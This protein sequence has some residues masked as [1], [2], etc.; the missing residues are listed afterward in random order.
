MGAAYVRAQQGGDIS[1]PTKVAAC[2]KHYLGYS[3]PLSG[4]DRTPAWIPERQL[5]EL[6]LKPF[7]AAVEAGVAT[8]MINSSEINGVPVHASKYYLTDLLRG[9]LGFEGFVVSDWADIENLYTREKVAKDRREAVKAAVQPQHRIC[10]ENARLC[11]HC[12][13]DAIMRELFAAKAKEHGVDLVVLNTK[14]EDQLA[15]HGLAYPLAI[16]LRQIPLL[17]L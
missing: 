11:P 2:M 14:D 7:A 13:L 4:K 15:M 5:R 3:F 6:F 10:H 8:A 9:E 1:D 12:T 16:E 17:M